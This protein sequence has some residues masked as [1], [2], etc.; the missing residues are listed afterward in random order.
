MMSFL[1]TLCEL[2][3]SL[4]NMCETD[5]EYNAYVDEMAQFV[6][7]PMFI[8]PPDTG[9]STKPKSFLHRKCEHTVIISIFVR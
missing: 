7:K 3:D 4:I 1:G 2:F 5:V 9:F 6:R 8:L